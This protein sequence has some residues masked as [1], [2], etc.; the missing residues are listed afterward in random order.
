MASPPPGARDDGALPAAFAV[1]CLAVHLTAVIHSGATRFGAP[2]NA[3][4]GNPPAF[5]DP[6]HEYG[7][8]AGTASS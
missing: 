4:P 2:F 6:A 5:T 8:N 7:R 3:A 1:A